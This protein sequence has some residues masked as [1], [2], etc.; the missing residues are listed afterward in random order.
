MGFGFELDWNRLC[1]SSLKKMS[2]SDRAH[3]KAKNRHFRYF[4]FAVAEVDEAKEIGS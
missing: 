2:K 1:Y 4:Y 3:I